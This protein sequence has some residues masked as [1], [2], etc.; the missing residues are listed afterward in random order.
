MCC[1]GP[2]NGTRSV[3]DLGSSSQF[4]SHGDHQPHFIQQDPLPLSQGQSSRSEPGNSTQHG[5]SQ[6]SH[7]G[8]TVNGPGRRDEIHKASSVSNLH[9]ENR[10]RAG[11]RTRDALPLIHTAGACALRTTYQRTVGVGTHLRSLWCVSKQLCE[12]SYAHP[13]TKPIHS[14]WLSVQWRTLCE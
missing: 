3:T 1:V 12:N 9:S 4:R 10:P 13:I 8:F 2:S 6:N 14:G 11:T 7:Q 5:C